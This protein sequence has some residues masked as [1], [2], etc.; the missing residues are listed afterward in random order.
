MAGWVCFYILFQK[1]VNLKNLSSFEVG[2][3]NV[4]LF[5][6]AL[7]GLTGHLPQTIY[8][9]VESFRLIAEEA[10]KRIIK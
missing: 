6:F 10:R 4:V 1:V 3:G 5:I 9:F 2:L 8:G 7:L